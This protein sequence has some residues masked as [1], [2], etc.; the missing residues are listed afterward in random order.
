MIRFGWIWI[1]YH[2]NLQIFWKQVKVVNEVIA[3]LE[4]TSLFI[5]ALLLFFFFL[6]VA[7]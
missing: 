6:R 7:L 1:D 3:V 4:Q 2:L 5:L